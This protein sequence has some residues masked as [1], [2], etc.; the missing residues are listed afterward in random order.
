MPPDT[1]HPPLDINIIV[2]T[3]RRLDRLEPSNI[4]SNTDWNFKKGNYETLYD[5]ISKV[6]WHDLYQLDDPFLSTK[7]FYDTLYHI[8]NVCI[9]KKRRNNYKSTRYPVWFTNDIISDT[10]RKL[11]LHCN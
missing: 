11:K 9:P 4:D 7:Y 10:K 5:M 3:R 6:S 2:A 8:F 1:Y